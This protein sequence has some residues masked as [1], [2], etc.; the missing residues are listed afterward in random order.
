MRANSRLDRSTTTPR[1]SRAALRAEEAGAGPSLLRAADLHARQLLGRGARLAGRARKDRAC[2]TR[3][4]D[5]P[6]RRSGGVLPEAALRPGCLVQ[7][8]PP[9]VRGRLRGMDREAV[10]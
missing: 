1:P 2:R 6:I 5:R 10:S 8:L 9:A 7:S 3:T 4:C